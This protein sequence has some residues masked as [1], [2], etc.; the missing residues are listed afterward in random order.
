MSTSA[1]SDT[2]ADTKLCQDPTSDTKSYTKPEKQVEN[3][4]IIRCQAN[5][6]WCLKEKVANKKG[7]PD[8]TVF[9]D[10][11][12]VYYIECKDR[13]KRPRPDQVSIHNKLRGLGHVVLLIDSKE[14]VKQFEFH[15]MFNI[16]ILPGSNLT[17]PEPKQ[18][19]RKGG[20]RA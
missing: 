2:N 18:A 4:L 6:W 14:K 5:N 7:W 20:T 17:Y 9:A 10:Q 13:G 15:V 12:R 8:R 19:K 3:Y 11:A 1:L 16:P